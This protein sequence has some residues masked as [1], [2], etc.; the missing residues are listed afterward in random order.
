MDCYLYSLPG[1]S[2]TLHLLSPLDKEVLSGMETRSEFFIG[3][4]LD[5]EKGIEPGNI[6]YNADFLVLLHGLVRDIM[7]NDPDVIQ[8]AAAQQ[9]GFVFIVDKRAP[10]GEEIRK[11]DIIGI[12]LVSE[13]KTNTANYRPNPDYELV[14]KRSV[15]IL[16][17]SVETA[18]L[19]KLLK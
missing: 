15:G 16:P 9:N 2:E 8:E 7:V 14:S 6:S 10:E 13:R 3:R 19:E 4:L 11:E 1:K 12:F 17:A 18:L 5:P